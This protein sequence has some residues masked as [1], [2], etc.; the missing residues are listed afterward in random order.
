MRTLTTL[1]VVA[2][3]LVWSPPDR[4]V[5]VQALVGDIVLCSWVRHLTLTVP[6]PTQVYKC[7]P[8]NLM[9]GAAMD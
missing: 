8:A 6:L 1:G 9:L 2:S 3:W 4:V 7:V 5:Q